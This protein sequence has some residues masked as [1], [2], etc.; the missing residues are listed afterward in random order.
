MHIRQIALVARDLAPALGALRDVFDLPE[1][2][3]D[4]GVGEFGLVNG[5]FPIGSGASSGFLEVVSPVREDA[6]A[7]RYLARRGGDGGYM[8]I[9]QST[10]LP[11]DRARLE[12]LGVRVVWKVSLPDIATVHLH[13]RD[14]PGAI[15][16]IDQPV[17]PET[18]RWG[19]PGWEAKRPSALVSEIVGATLQSDDAEKLARRWSD[20]LARSAPRREGDGFVLALDRGHAIRF[21]ACDDARGEGLCGVSLRAR[22]ADEVRRRARARGALADDGAV[23]LGGVRFVLV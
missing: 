13:P 11:A 3:P 8:V 17:V 10:D 1:P 21:V 15:V 12:R 23:T 22:D 16:S 2:F 20:V 5:V 19:G 7:A 6:T 4:P 9:L 14:L 18:W